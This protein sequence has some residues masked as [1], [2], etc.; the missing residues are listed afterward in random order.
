M[1]SVLVYTCMYIKSLQSILVKSSSSTTTLGSWQPWTWN[2]RIIFRV[3]IPFLVRTLARI[4]G[5]TFICNAFFAALDMTLR[6]A[7]SLCELRQRLL[8]PGRHEYERPSGIPHIPPRSKD[9]SYEQCTITE[10]VRTSAR[11][12]FG[13][14]TE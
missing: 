6:T 11:S 13:Q 8:M 9:T 1:Q 4:A 10:P 14:M 5:I 2:S 3:E 12:N 7:T